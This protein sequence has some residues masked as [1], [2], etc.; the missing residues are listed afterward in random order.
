MLCNIVSAFKRAYKSSVILWLFRAHL[1]LSLS[2]WLIWVNAEALPGYVLYSPCQNE[3]K[4]YLLTTA[5]DTAHVWTHARGGAY[6]SVLLEN[7][8][9]LRPAESPVH[10]LTGA[11]AQNG[12]IQ[13]IDRD[14][15]VVWE[16]TYKSD[17]YVLHHGIWV[18]PNG[19]I[20]A[21]AFEKRTRQEVQQVGLAHVPPVFMSRDGSVLMEQIIEIDPTKP[22]GQEIVWMWR[23]WDHL[24]SADQAA[25]NPH[26]FSTDLGAGSDYMFS[27]WMHLNGIAYNPDL[28]QIVFSSRVFGEIYIIDHSTTTEQAAGHTGGRYGKGG[29]LLYRWGNSSNYKIHGGSSLDVLHNPSWV[30]NG[31]PGAG[32]IIFFHNNVAANVSQ[33][34]EITPPINQNGTYELSAGSSYG[35]MQPTWTYSADGFYSPYMSSCQRLPNG[36]TFICE[37][38]PNG[39]LR[40]VNAQGEL[41]W[42][43][44]PN[45]FPAR[46]AKYEEGHPGIQRLLGISK[47]QKHVKKTVNTAV[48]IAYRPGQILLSDASGC[49]LII[50]SVQGKKL[51]SSRITKN[52]HTIDTHFLQEGV[53]VISAVS[54]KGNVSRKV[55]VIH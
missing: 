48:S 5:G 34:I 19:N 3:T 23:V 38:Y 46:A 21:S 39:R 22:T 14:G 24:V 55:R 37:A 43:Y 53:Y 49:E 13:E 31:Y 18:M 7:G 47:S 29:A 40:E 44:V 28:D 35:P 20:L 50:C 10:G 54:A 32:N 15:N 33:V 11:A 4:T 42:E 9:L 16:F 26:L 45:V 52:V 41:L 2:G 36:N 51:L 6:G 17:Q 8:N 30:P 1:I 25:A 12:V 27:D